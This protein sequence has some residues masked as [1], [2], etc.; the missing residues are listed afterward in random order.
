MSKHTLFLFFN[1]L[2]LPTFS[3]NS[4]ASFINSEYVQDL[5]FHHVNRCRSRPI[6]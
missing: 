3:L 1:A 5:V 6:S 4:L 2:L